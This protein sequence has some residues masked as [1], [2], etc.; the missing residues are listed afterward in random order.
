M[1]IKKIHVPVPHQNFVGTGLA[2]A[3]ALGHPFKPQVIAHHIVPTPQVAVPAVYPVATGPY[4]ADLVEQIRL[5]NIE[6]AKGVKAEV[7]EHCRKAGIAFS[8]TSSRQ[9]ELHIRYW[10]QEDAI[11]P[12]GYA[13]AARLADL[14]VIARPEE[15]VTR[16]TTTLFETLVFQSSQPVIITPE[17]ANISDKA[18][19]V[20]AWDGGKEAARALNA[21]LPLLHHAK[22]V[23]ILTVGNLS[24]RLP[25]ANDVVKH[26]ASHSIEATA[27]KR[28]DKD[29]DAETV[30]HETSKELGANLIVMGAYSHTRLREMVLGGVTRHMTRHSEIPVLLAH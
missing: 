2:L 10:E 16:E 22:Q 8:D 25:S 6:T 18:S 28:D 9:Q 4:V 13:L 30:I 12:D 11:Y 21:S 14:V 1:S 5:A 17:N 19:V 20:I 26:L 3:T 7:E 29:N 27:T 24:G 15:D 23:S